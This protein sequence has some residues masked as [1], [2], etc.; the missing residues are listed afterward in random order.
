MSNKICFV[1]PKILK[2]F[3]FI[4]RDRSSLVAI[5]S[6]L[7]Q[8]MRKMKHDRDRQRLLDKMAEAIKRPDELENVDGDRL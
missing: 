6:R 5:D 2:N 4:F 1:I 8:A 3:T 7:R